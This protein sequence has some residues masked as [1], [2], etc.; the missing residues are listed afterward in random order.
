MINKNYKTPFVLSFLLIAV[1]SSTI[2]FTNK[3]IV[4][5]HYNFGLQ[6]D[7]FGSK[8][9]LIEIILINLSI[10][11]ILLYLSTKPHLLNYPIEI[12]EQTKESAYHKMILFLGYLALISTTIFTLTVLYSTL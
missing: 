8:Y 5:L 7:R 12:T 9:E 4:A 10:V 3:S 2:F 6:P 11:M 1:Y